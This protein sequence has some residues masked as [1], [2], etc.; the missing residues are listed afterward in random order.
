M[1]TGAPVQSSTRS[2]A[3]GPRSCALKPDGAGAYTVFSANCASASGPSLAGGGLAGVTVSVAPYE[4][5][6]ARRSSLMSATAMRRALKALA[7]ARQSRPTGP[8]P[9]MATSEASAKLWRGGRRES[10]GA[11]RRRRRRVG[12]ETTHSD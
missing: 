5:A 10:C 7:T 3:S 11:S 8:A 6:N 12:R 4:R 1:Q 2:N 9:K